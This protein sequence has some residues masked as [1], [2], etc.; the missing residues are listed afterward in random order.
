MRFLSRF[1]AMCEHMPYIKRS[2]RHISRVIRRMESWHRP[3]HQDSV[4]VCVRIS[5]SC[6]SASRRISKTHSGCIVE[7]N[8]ICEE[9]DSRVA[10]KKLRGFRN[11]KGPTTERLSVNRSAGPRAGSS[12]LS[13]DLMNEPREYREDESTE[14]RR[15]ESR[16]SKTRHYK[17]HAPEEQR[18]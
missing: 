7:R 13:D 2:A 11:P 14:K 3:N 1:L 18:V 4:R 12:F 15:P 17:R 16:H 6:S 10:E 5:Q 8:T 9:K